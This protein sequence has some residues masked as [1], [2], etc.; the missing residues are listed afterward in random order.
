MLFSSLPGGHGGYPTS[1]EGT[2]CVTLWPCIWAR[3][4]YI[5][6]GSRHKSACPEAE[7]WE[8][9]LPRQWG[10]Q[11]REDGVLISSAHFSL[12]RG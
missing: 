3:G 1:H 6:L 2:L 11:G 9:G 4:I 12:E 10:K 8:L 5:F 7:N